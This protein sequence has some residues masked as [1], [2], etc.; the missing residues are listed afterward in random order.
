MATIATTRGMPAVYNASAPTLTDGTPGALNM[1]VNANLKITQ[2]TL[3]AGEDL[4]NNVAGVAIKPLSVAAYA[5]SMVQ[6]T[7]LEA[8]H[9][10]KAAA[11]NLYGIFGY[12]NRV[13]SQF[14][15]V[16]NSAT[17]P[18][19]TAVPIIT[20]TVPASSNFSLDLGQLPIQFGTGISV[21]NSS[22]AATK[23]AGSADCFF[24]VLY[25]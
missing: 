13:S 6:S 8:S 25:S 4:T 2:G 5:A 3:L 19:D 23:T 7:A 24:N 9:V 14:I 17:V 16:F 15:Q 18:A 21:S 11:G 1:D 12:S 20:F 22:T 10:I